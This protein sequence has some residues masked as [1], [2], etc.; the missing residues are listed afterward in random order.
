MSDYRETL[1]EDE[2]FEMKKQA[3]KKLADP[4]SETR[5][6]LESICSSLK[7]VP[8]VTC[9]AGR[10]SELDKEDQ[11]EQEYIKHRQI[12]EEQR[13]PVQSKQQQTFKSIRDAFRKK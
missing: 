11:Q 4:D 2:E 7:G 13:A 6:V 1:S 10:Q 12:L 9:R 5:G 3:A 8:G